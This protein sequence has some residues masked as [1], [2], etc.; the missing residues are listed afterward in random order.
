MEQLSPGRVDP[1]LSDVVASSYQRDI[2]SDHN[3]SLSSQEDDTSESHGGSSVEGQDEDNETVESV[4]SEVLEQIVNRVVANVETESLVDDDQSS[5]AEDV[6]TVIATVVETLV[7]Q[8]AEM[9]SC[10]VTPTNIDDIDGI[11]EKQT[12]D[13]VK[14]EDENFV[15][16]AGLP[17][18]AIDM[19]NDDGDHVTLT[20]HH[21][22]CEDELEIGDDKEDIDSQFLRHSRGFSLDS[23]GGHPIA[24]LSVDA[25]SG[26][27]SSQTNTEHVGL[28]KTQS[29]SSPVDISGVGLEFETN[30]EIQQRILNGVSE[31]LVVNDHPSQNGSGIDGDNEEEVSVTETDETDGTISEAILLARQSMPAKFL[32][33][34]ASRSSTSP[35]EREFL[36]KIRQG[37][38][39]PEEEP[40]DELMMPNTR[41]A[42]TSLDFGK[43]DKGT[44]SFGRVVEMEE[45]GVLKS[46][47]S[48]DVRLNEQLER[49]SDTRRARSM[50][51][52]SVVSCHVLSLC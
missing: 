29:L 38:D 9:T 28:R 37:E 6:E 20:P 25:L 13:L 51:C 4:V 40:E 10:L 36:K 52:L 42:G 30:S 12:W 3:L 7:D 11:S 48:P 33:D 5:D 35:A 44:P 8:V 26:E 1:S 15:G 23:A 31:E 14:N 21:S 46:S 18:T 24:V 34:D 41:M 2:E 32:F 43:R 47:S 49:I 50:C 45:V 19:L 16:K 39:E 22:D 17:L 27:L